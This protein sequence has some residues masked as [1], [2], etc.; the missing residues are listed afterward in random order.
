M[1][2]PNSIRGITRRYRKE[3]EAWKNMRKRC[4]NPRHPDYHNYGGR[5]ISICDRWNQSFASFLEDVGPA[6]DKSMSIDR[7]PN[8]DGNYEPGNC[9]WATRTEQARNTR[10]AYPPR[11]HLPYYSLH[12]ATGQARGRINGQ[13][14]Y[15]GKYGTLASIRAYVAAMTA[16]GISF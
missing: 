13:C 12:K 9:R 4:N 7:F 11:L 5:G 16:A 2:T 1:A 3:H 15:F 8:N 6:P 10:A 14:I